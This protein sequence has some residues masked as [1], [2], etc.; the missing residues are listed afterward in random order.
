[1]FWKGYTGCDDMLLNNSPLFASIYLDA[2]WPPLLKSLVSVT[3]ANELMREMAMVS[4]ALV[5]SRGEGSIMFELSM[6]LIWWA[7]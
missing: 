5:G 4:S 7:A 3:R 6:D 2:L 1:M